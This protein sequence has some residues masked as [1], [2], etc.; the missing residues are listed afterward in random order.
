ML[1]NATIY[2]VGSVSSGLSALATAA[3]LSVAGILV[4]RRWVETEMR[5]L[6]N[7]NE[8]PEEKNHAELG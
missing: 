3:V 2:W 5:P 1:A 4:G 8:E 7:N 6:N